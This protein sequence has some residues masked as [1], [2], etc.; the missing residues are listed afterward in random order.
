MKRWGTAF[1]RWLTVADDPK[2]GWWKIAKRWL[3]RIFCFFGFTNFI[4]AILIV[5]IALLEPDSTIDLTTT[6]VLKD[7][8]LKRQVG[9]LS[10]DI[11]SALPIEVREVS[12]PP[13]PQ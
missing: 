5:V 2:T 1:W 10:Q 9:D 6:V 13:R 11:S 12:L 8:V 4:A 3:F 7:A